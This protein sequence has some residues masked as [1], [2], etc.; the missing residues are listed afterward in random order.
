M[1]YYTY[2]DEN[3]YTG[4]SDDESAN[5]TTVEPTSY[6]H[7][8]WD[9]DKWIIPDDIP[10]TFEELQKQKIEDI[11]QYFDEMVQNVS[12]ANGADFEQ[13]TWET[14]RNE[15]MLYSASPSANTPYIDTLSATRGVTKDYLLGRIGYNVLGYAQIQGNLHKYEDMINACTTEEELDQIVW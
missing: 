1:K 14:Q 13:D 9:I 11:R 10:P 12:H 6:D 5:S 4:F 8:L 7:I 15:W 3:I 2:N